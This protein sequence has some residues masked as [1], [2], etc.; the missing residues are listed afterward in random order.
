[1]SVYISTNTHKHTFNYKWGLG[2]NSSNTGAKNVIFLK[3]RLLFFWANR[4]LHHCLSAPS[5]CSTFPACFILYSLY[6]CVQ[7]SCVRHRRHAVPA[8][9]GVTVSSPWVCLLAPGAGNTV[10]NGRQLK[11]PRQER[12]GHFTPHLFSS[13]RSGK[14]SQSASKGIKI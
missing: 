11:S 8:Q 1:M 2:S 14:W 3:C 5:I 12:R 7:S 6:E 10:L 9:R 13:K 4:S